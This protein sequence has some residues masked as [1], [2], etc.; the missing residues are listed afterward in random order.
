MD[1]PYTYS[2]DG[3][4]EVT[5][6]DNTKAIVSHGLNAGLAILTKRPG[7][8]MKEAASL[9]SLLTQKNDPNALEKTKRE[10]TSPAHVVQFSGCKD[11]QTSA[12]AVIGGE[13]TGAMSWAL[14]TALNQNKNR[15]L[16]D[17]LKELRRLLRGKYQQTPQMST[18]HPWNVA[19][20]IFTIV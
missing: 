3:R 15:T 11:N 5:F 18:S 7:A 20:D 9:F 6:Q 19:Q 17:L 16:T 13:A 8:A 1:L 12:D 14:I 4:E 10:K 2:V